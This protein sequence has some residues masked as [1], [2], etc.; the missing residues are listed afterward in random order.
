MPAAVLARSWATAQARALFGGVAA[1]ALAPLNRPMS[2]AV[3]MA[4]TCSCHAFGWPVARGGSKSIT[5]ALAAH[6]QAG[7]GRGETGARVG[8]LAQLPAVDA[9]VF[10]LAPRQRP[11]IAPAR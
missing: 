1:H 8:A 2:S 5:D 4:L 9:V 6:V 10:G 11:P 7:G 3:G